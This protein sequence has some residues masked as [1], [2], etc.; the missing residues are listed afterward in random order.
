MREKVGFAPGPSAMSHHATGY[1]PANRFSWYWGHWGPV[2]IVVGMP[3]PS[4]SD[5][6]TEDASCQSENPCA[7]GSVIVHAFPFGRYHWPAFC[8]SPALFS[9]E[10]AV[11]VLGA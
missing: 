1:L 2:A 7:T 3:K 10:V 5:L 8:V 11:A 4:S 9:S 6:I